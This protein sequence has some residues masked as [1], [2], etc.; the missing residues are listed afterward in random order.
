MKFSCDKTS[1]CDAVSN[2]SKAVAQ[3]TTITALEGIKIKLTENILELTGY[4]LEIGIT[5]T[6]TVNSEDSGEF[7]VDAKL[8]NEFVRKMPGDVVFIE[9]ND[10]QMSISSDNTDCSLSVISAEEYPDM[11]EFDKECTVE[12]RQSILKTMISKTSFATSTNENKPILT[13]ELFEFEDGVLNVVAI[14]GLRL[15]IKTENIGCKE[16]LKFVV[17][18]KTLNEIVSI[19]KDESDKACTLFTNKKHI[20]FDINGY[21]VISRLLE[22]EFHNYR[23][24]LNGEYKTEIILNVRDLLSS[25]ERCSLIVNDKNRAPAVCNFKS[26]AVNVE[27]KTALGKVKDSFGADISGDAVTIGVNSKFML[28]A[29]KAAEG[30]KVKIQLNGAMRAI[31]IIPL[32]GND[33]TYLIMPVQLR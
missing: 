20:I 27:C 2:V 28:D 7:V 23:M 18:K 12:I 4:D 10:S 30:D 33:F 13:G 11:P 14:D 26:G 19:I 24:S 16:N 5:T 1:L 17:P 9:I 21:K 6:V 31:K 3:K 25:M 29:L 15:A 22:G 32:E 8:F